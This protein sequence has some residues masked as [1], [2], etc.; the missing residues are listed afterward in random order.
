[1]QGRFTR[2]VALLTEP[3]AA[4]IFSLAEPENLSAVTL[5]ATV[6][7][8]VPSTFTGRPLRTAPLATSSATVTSPPSGNSVEMVSRFTTW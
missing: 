6:S 8:P 2:G 3:P 4:S 5:T 7:S 1:M